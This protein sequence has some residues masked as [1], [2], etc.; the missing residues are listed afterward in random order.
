MEGLNKTLTFLSLL[1]TMNEQTK[2]NTHA[3]NTVS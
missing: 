1:S 3:D 2:G